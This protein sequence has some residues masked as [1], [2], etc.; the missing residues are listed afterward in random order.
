M[1]A[2]LARL[3]IDCGAYEAA[4]GRS[5]LEDFAPHWRVLEEARLVRVEGRDRIELTPSDMFYADA[6]AGLLAHW[7]ILEIAE[8]RDD[9]AALRQHMG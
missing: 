6:I 2:Y 1:I 8:E 3:S 7:R 4:F 9:L 5:P